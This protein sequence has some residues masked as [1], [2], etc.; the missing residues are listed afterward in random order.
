L[1]QIL[2]IKAVRPVNP[3]FAVAK[4]GCVNPMPNAYD[5]HEKASMPL[6]IIEKSLKSQAA[7]IHAA[8]TLSLF[9][10]IWRAKLGAWQSGK[11]VHAWRKSRRENGR[12]V[13]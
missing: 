8:V 5:R 1:I 3:G 6:P 11:A 13:R 12:G 7:S 10:R 4:P 9:L 2:R